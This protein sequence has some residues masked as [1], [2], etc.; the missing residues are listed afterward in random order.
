MRVLTFVACCYAAAL[1][2]AASLF[3]V[4]DDVLF[5]HSDALSK[6][7]FLVALGFVLLPAAVPVVG[8]AALLGRRT[9]ALKAAAA[10]PLALLLAGFLIFGGEWA[11]GRIDSFALYLTCLLAAILLSALLVWRL[12]NRAVVL[13]R[14]AQLSRAI[15][16]AA[17]PFALAAWLYHHLDRGGV[18][19]AEARHVV[20][21][22][23]DGMPSQ[24]MARYAPGQPPTELDRVAQRGCV[25]EHAYTNRTYTSGYF[26]VFYTGAYSGRAREPG[27]ALPQAAER[28][29]AGFRWVSFHSNG[30]PETAKIT[31]YSGLRS[32]QLSERWAWLPRFLGLHYHVFLTWDDTRRYMGDR[33]NTLYTALNGKTD[34]EGFWR[35]VLPRQIEEMQARYSRSFLLVHVS[36]TKN[37][38]QA[39]A[40]GSFGDHAADFQSL[41]SHAIANDYTYTPDQARIVEAYR[42]YYRDRLDEYGR[43][44]GGLLDTLE[45]TSRSRNTLVLVTADHGSTFSDGKLWYGPHPDE[46]TARVPLL[47]FG[48]GTRCAATPAVDTLDVRA[49]I[50]SFLGL[51]ATSGSLGRN[52]LTPLP[53]AS[54]RMVPVLTVHNHKRKT[55]FLE[56]HPEPGLR[57]L[58]N[59]APEGDGRA[60]KGIVRGYEVHET[61]LGDEPAAWQMLGKALGLY[62]IEPA[63]IH[64]GLRTRIGQHIAVQ[65][66]K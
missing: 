10:V 57:Y 46:Q 29:G 56:L 9:G 53:A 5:F 36:T 18:N 45:K 28:A 54:A 13:G 52:L 64:A 12:P 7:Y 63:S 35:D 65:P 20:M 25:I 23:V 34:E 47:L 48:G 30:F 17:V 21:V 51:T 49:T 22:L 62:E 1:W 15:L 61:P 32:A 6:S 3:G 16:F 11:F 42:Q 66:A 44:I 26:S 39:L 24:L 50:D 31:G 33:V 43:R 59:L 4:S 41:M 8:A 2:A 38:V 55:W 19:P 58:F 60:M 37:T 27:A 40:D 14:A